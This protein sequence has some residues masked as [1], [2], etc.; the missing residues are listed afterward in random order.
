MSGLCGP[1]LSGLP[2]PPQADANAKLQASQRE[3]GFLKQLN[4]TLLANQK[5]YQ[6]R[7]AAAQVTDWHS[8]AL[9]PCYKVA[10][11]YLTFVL[12][13]G[14]AVCSVCV[15]CSRRWVGK[16]GFYLL[17]HGTWFV[18]PNP[19]CSP[20]ILSAPRFACCPS[21]ACC[22]IG[23]CHSTISAKPRLMA[24]CLW[25]AAGAARECHAAAGR[26]HTGPARPGGG[27]GDE[28][29]VGVSLHPASCSLQLWSCSCSGGVDSMGVWRDSATV[30]LRQPEQAWMLGMWWQHVP[31]PVCPLHAAL[32]PGCL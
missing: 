29:G 1:H 24:A 11:S 23:S 25:P 20:P 9:P 2:P 31:L 32:L 3:A 10:G 8:T 21:F 6:A 4:D 12:G 13:V 27:A 28:G 5:D 22:D 19:A 17:V 16:T 26:D 15:W 14:T 18:Q 7:L 30:L